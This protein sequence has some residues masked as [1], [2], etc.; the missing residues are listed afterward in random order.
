MPPNSYR[1]F[2]LA[3]QGEWHVKDTPVDGPCLTRGLPHAYD[4]QITA[5]EEI[6]MSRN[7]IEFVGSRRFLQFA[8]SVSFPNRIFFDAWG[9]WLDTA[10]FEVVDG[11]LQLPKTLTVM[12]GGG[13][14]M[15]WNKRP[16]EAVSTG[17]A[18]VA[19]PG[20]VAQPTIQQEVQPV[21]IVRIP[22]KGGCGRGVCSCPK[23]GLWCWDVMRFDLNRPADER[24]L[25]YEIIV[26]SIVTNACLL[27]S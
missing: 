25:R 24:L 27:R 6:I 16:K 8:S 5:G 14:K 4:L 9:S 11:T 23:D 12:H 17:E 15:T 10:A 20:V 26:C 3:L 1:S 7:G 13:Y 22:V 2:F 18:P 19:P 21:E